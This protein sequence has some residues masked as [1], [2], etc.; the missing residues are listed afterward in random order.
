MAEG[1]QRL[2]LGV[3]VV[4]VADV[5]TF[6]VEHFV[7]FAWPVVPGWGVLDAFGECALFKSAGYSVREERYLLGACRLGSRCRIA[8]Q[9]MH[10][11][12]LDLGTSLGE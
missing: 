6:A 8:H 2:D 12:L 4:P 7:V 1:K 10:Y 11:L 5:E 3:V 9:P